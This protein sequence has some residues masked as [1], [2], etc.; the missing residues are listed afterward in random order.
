MVQW[1]LKRG[2]VP[3]FGGSILPTTAQGADDAQMKSPFSKLAE[4]PQQR[5]WAIAAVAAVIVIIFFLLPSSRA[6]NEIGNAVR[7]RGVAK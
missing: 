7:A 1:M 2:A 6:G 4:N 5:K 3:T